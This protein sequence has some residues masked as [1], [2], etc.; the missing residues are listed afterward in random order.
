MSHESG[1]SRQAGSHLTLTRDAA[2]TMAEYDALA[3]LFLGEGGPAIAATPAPVA[4]PA[5]RTL[6]LTGSDAPAPKAA[7]VRAP[8][9]ENNSS[10]PVKPVDPPS[11]FEAVALGHL[12]V[13]A[14]AW[15]MQY[16]RSLATEKQ[17]A[18][19]MLRVGG[20][21]V[22][23]EL[24]GDHTSTDSTHAA[25]LEQAVGRALRVAGAWLLRVDEPTETELAD[26]P[27][28]SAIT[29]L[30][31]AD[32]VAIVN[33]YRAIKGYLELGLIGREGEDE[34][35]RMS[36][37]LAVMGSP[38]DRAK[39]AAARI[40]KAATTYLG[41]AVESVICSPKIS[42]VA[43]RTLFRSETERTV[44]EIV[45]G[46]IAAWA[47]IPG[48]TQTPLASS[49]TPA[50]SVIS[51]P[52]G[53]A[54]DLP[55]NEIT[56]KLPSSSD[57]LAD[58]IPDGLEGLPVSE[59]PASELTPDE[60][61]IAERVIA[62][63]HPMPEPRAAAPMLEPLPIE[64]SGSRIGP[65]TSP[66]GSAGHVQHLTQHLAQHLAGLCALNIKCPFA[67]AAE[68]ACA[69]DGTL[70]IIGLA[71]LAGDAARVVESLLAAASWAEVHVEILRQI[72][73][74]LRAG[75]GK[76]VLHLLAD[77]AKDVRPLIDSDIRLHAIVRG[78]G[79]SSTVADLN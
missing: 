52:V 14:S 3:D 32:E 34:E 71:G 12:P 26:I 30:T 36:L 40:R 17:I 44:R 2:G 62:E 23:L 68:L 69:C 54:S 13:M 5:M 74:G 77:R 50:A 73:P 42:P 27:G 35:P 76:T 10:T 49:E 45:A 57:A 4:T 29:L 21:K 33:S 1:G 11:G 78:P 19:A 61:S 72:H 60:R 75:Q 41:C 15:A 16:A 64:S 31:G 9:V 22:S 56:S 18:V 20:G 58:I 70:H 7:P 55:A 8:K 46:V 51:M 28:V 48:V 66:A 43:T 47:S 24:I 6:K 38:E 37:R 25:S 65:R 59:A 39:E 53:L 67:P 79:G 63:R